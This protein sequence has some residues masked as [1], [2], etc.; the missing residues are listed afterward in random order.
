MDSA[1]EK[2]FLD[3]LLNRSNGETNATINGS[4]SLRRCLIVTD[5]EPDDMIA[6]HMLLPELLKRN[7]IPDVV[8]SSWADVRSKTIFVH[9]YLSNMTN[10]ISIKIYLGLPTKKIYDISSMLSGTDVNK[11]VTF[12]EWNALNWA[13]YSLIIQ[14]S[15]INELMELYL[16]GT[17]FENVNLAI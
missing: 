12:D 1:Q 5:W 3:R 2:T 8:V 15:P 17:S 4:Q 16:G 13:A 14:L 10:D 9:Q 11:A 6:I 7:I